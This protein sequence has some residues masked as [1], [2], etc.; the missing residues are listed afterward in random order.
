MMPYAQY[1]ETAV[2]AARA[3]AAVLERHHQ[4]RADLVIDHKGKNDLVSEADRQAEQ[5]AVA[6]LQQETDALGIIGEEF[7]GQAGAQATW[8]LDP[9]DGTTNYLHGLPHYAVSIGLVA[10]AGTLD[11]TG[12]TLKHD[13]PVLGVVYDIARQEMFTAM[14]G[15]GAWLNGQRIG[16][17]KTHQI[18][19]A[20]V[21]TGIPMR[22]FS[23]LEQ[24]LAALKDLVLNTRGIRRYGSAALDLCW[25]AAGRFDAYWEQGIQSW[26]VAAGTVIARQAGAVVLD[27]YDPKASW[28]ASGRV[29]ASTPLLTNQLMGKILPHMQGAPGL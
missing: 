28:P 10:K 15:V 6:I 26:D 16:C 12:E 24:Y 21:A 9:L 18:S 8:Y 22:N 29:L 17:T 14:H 4:R 7:G 20:L 2:R 1:L 27:P 23:Y 3:S 5:A 11:P 19:E 25:V 13:E